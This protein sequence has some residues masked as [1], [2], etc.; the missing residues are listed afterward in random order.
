M[1]RI[2]LFLV[3]AGAVILAQFADRTTANLP[4]GQSLATRQQAADDAIVTGAI[5]R[6][7][8]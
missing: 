1:S 4:G 3:A 6:Q 5:R 2:V 7:L 8:R